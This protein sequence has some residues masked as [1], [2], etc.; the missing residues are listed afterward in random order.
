MSV[1]VGREDLQERHEG[2]HDGDVH[3]DGALAIQYRGEHRDALLR[4]DLRQCPASGLADCK[5]KELASSFAIWNMK[6]SGN[7]SLLRRTARLRLPVQE[8]PPLDHFSRMG[9]GGSGAWL[10]EST[11]PYGRG[12]VKVTVE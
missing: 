2:A 10:G 6:S 4:E 12:S 7:R 9:R 1:F 8:D 11:A 3:G 5:S